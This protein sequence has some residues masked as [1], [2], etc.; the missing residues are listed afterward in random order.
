MNSIQILLNFLSCNSSTELTVFNC[1]FQHPWTASI[2]KETICATCRNTIF[3]I[4]CGASLITQ[5]HLLTAAHCLFDEN[6][7]Q[8]RGNNEDLLGKYP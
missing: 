5:R 6:T 1:I 3:E 2:L 7:G 8:K 4:R